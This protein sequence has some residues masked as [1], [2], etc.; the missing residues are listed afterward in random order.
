MKKL[1]NMNKLQREIIDRAGATIL[2]NLWNR[3]KCYLCGDHIV[4][5][6]INTKE[7]YTVFGPHLHTCMRCAN[8]LLR[9]TG[10]ILQGQPDQQCIK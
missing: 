10:K 5:I 3:P 1:P 9:E 7:V 4:S 8:I 6:D 2:N